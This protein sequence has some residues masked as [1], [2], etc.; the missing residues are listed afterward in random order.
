MVSLIYAKLDEP[1]YTRIRCGRGFSYRGLNG[2]PLK[3]RSLLDYCRSLVIP[4][5]WRD[6][7][8]S[9]V[10]QA[11]ILCRGTD[12]ADRKQ[13]LYHPQWT[14]VQNERKFDDLVAFAAC[15]PNLR[16]QIETDMNAARFS[17]HRV[18]AS[19]LRL[20][21]K[22]LV[23]VG[24]EQYL[25]DNGTRG[26]TT[27]IASTVNVSGSHITL[28]FK[29]KSGKQHHIELMDD[30]LARSISYCQELP[31]QRLFQYLDEDGVAVNID[32]ADVNDY[33][34]AATGQE[35]TAK[36]FRTWGGSVAACTFLHEHLSGNKQCDAGKK[37]ESTMVRHVADR[38]GNTVSVARK[39][40]IH[41]RLL[42]AAKSCQPIE[43]SS[44]ALSGLSREES[45]LSRF[46]KT[47]PASRR[48]TR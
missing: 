16:Q 42:K 25:R 10:R 4:P 39:Y 5:A 19:T 23:R 28:D 3:R 6:V 34:R 38:L 33:L 15:L 32:S 46:L 35:F 22:G 14:K 13:Y 48:E 26:A 12:E 37:L 11:H 41:P 21:D 44:R 47:E 24:N 31:G 45:R 2:K 8:I 30:A 27:L 18:T 36:H 7:W 1:G 17:K 29:G 9:P 40:Y 20:I 43:V